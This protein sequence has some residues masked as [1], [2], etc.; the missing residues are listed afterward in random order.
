MIVGANEKAIKIYMFGIDYV[1]LEPV[2]P[3]KR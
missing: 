2:E 3:E 1:Q